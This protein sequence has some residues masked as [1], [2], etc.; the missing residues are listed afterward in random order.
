MA[1]AAYQT[2]KT[3]Q[4]MLDQKNDQLKRKEDHFISLSIHFYLLR[5][6]DLAE[7][8]VIIVF[9]FHACD[10]KLK[11]SSFLGYFV[12]QNFFCMNCETNLASECAPKSPCL[13]G[14]EKS[15]I[16]QPN[17]EKLQFKGSK[18]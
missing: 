15:K 13:T 10:M 3:M 9:I 7:N 8:F 16:H 2:I 12:T 17:P 14:F 5:F 6:F 1:D 4:E 11:N 18:I